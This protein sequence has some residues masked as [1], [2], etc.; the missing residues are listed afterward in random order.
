ME[1]LFWQLTVG[2]ESEKVLVMLQKADWT[3]IG[4]VGKNKSFCDRMEMKDAIL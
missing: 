3:I 2:K 4:Y 1:S